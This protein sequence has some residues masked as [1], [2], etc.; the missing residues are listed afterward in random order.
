MM[1]HAEDLATIANAAARLRAAADAGSESPRIARF[2]VDGHALLAIAYSLS[3]D[4]TV[5]QQ[6]ASDDRPLVGQ[7][8]C[9]G[10]RYLVYDVDTE[11]AAKR[12]ATPSAVDVLTRRE[13]QIALLIGD[14]KGDKEIAQLL[15]I[16][17][18]TVRE[19]IRRIF[20]KLNVGR[21]AAIVSHV[22]RQSAAAADW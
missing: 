5:E 16:S 7:I 17:G 12:N 14:G 2:V 6:P 11:M 9:A 1:M 4:R 22:L 21:R 18:Y 13:L 15:G 3:G 19:H 10:I 20:A 8:T